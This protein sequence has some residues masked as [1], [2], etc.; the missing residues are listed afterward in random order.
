MRE[1]NFYDISI[2]L[3]SLD[4][5]ILKEMNCNTTAEKILETLALIKE[6][7]IEEEHV[8]C[9]YGFPSD[10]RPSIY[11][12]IKLGNN[13]GYKTL[14]A[15]VMPLPGT[16]MHKYCLEKGIIADELSYM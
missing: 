3:E 8:R 12:S 4:N 7:G 14:F 13:L 10:D 15:L 5:R 16:D 9:L 6:A 1:A 11:N 2:G